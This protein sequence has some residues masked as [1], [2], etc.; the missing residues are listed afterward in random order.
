MARKLA[1][2]RTTM[3]Y[4]I[5]LVLIFVS[6]LVFGSGEMLDTHFFYSGEYAWAFF[7]SLSEEA[8][9]AY[10]RT[11]LLDFLFIHFY[12]SLAFHEFSKLL[13]SKARF[14]ALVPGFFDL[15]ETG[16]IFRILWS[17]MI[18]SDLTALGYMTAA[19]WTSG[20]ILILVYLGLLL[21]RR[22]TH[23]GS[24]I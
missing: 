8:R 22:R 14:V 1:I 21:R 24:S 20:A 7:T 10:L 2:D 6:M 16:T 18:P 4:L 3:K 5:G 23:S 17:G 12:S 9:H 15:M 11:N 19:K 13:K